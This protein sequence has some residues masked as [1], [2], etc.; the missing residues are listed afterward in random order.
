MLGQKSII[1]LI[2]LGFSYFLK[3]YLTWGTI[4][5]CFFTVGIFVTSL[6]IPK[7][8][9][10]LLALVLIGSYIF[11]YGKIFDPEVGLNF[12]TSVV[13]LKI[14]EN[15]TER[16]RYMIFFGLILLTGAGALFEK[17]LEYALFLLG[18]FFFLLSHF[19]KDREFRWA[20]KE[21]LTSL[22]LILPLVGTLFFVVPRIMSPMSLFGAQ[23]QKGKIGYSKSVNMED[24]DSLTAND[25][26]AFYAVVP[27]IVPQ[28]ELYWRGNVLTLTDGWNWIEAPKETGVSLRDEDFEFK[29]LK[30]EI[31]LLKPSDYFFMLDWPLAL[32]TELKDRRIGESGT[33]SQERR[34]KVQRYSVWSRKESILSPSESR[35][36]TIS[37]LKARDKKW[38]KETFQSQDAQELIREIQDY[39]RNENFTYTLSPGR[40]SSFEEFMK[41][42]RGFCT[43]FASA[44]AQILRAKGIPVRLISGYMGGIYNRIGGYYQVTENDAH[45]W[46]EVPSPEGWRRFDPTAW[47]SPERV[48]LGGDIFVK[49][50]SGAGGFEL[51]EF[52]PLKKIGFIQDLR[53]EFERLNFDFYRLLEEMNYFTQLTLLR[54]MGLKKKFMLILIPVIILFFAA[55]YLLILRILRREKDIEALAWRKFRKKL[56]ARESTSLNSIREIEARIKE[57]EAEKRFEAQRVLKSLVG[58]SFGEEKIAL[59]SLIKEI[60]RL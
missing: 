49:E 12:L 15:E 20:K 53:F 59:D 10:V 21:I 22:L 25:E 27:Q 37:A 38:V 47:I 14:L 32:R 60:R 28:N 34:E 51:G 56:G 29:G 30:Q 55:L 36:L 7:F 11:V 57:M 6:K 54:K 44:T 41:E 2:I 43:H 46:V 33:L 50:K 17:T 35:G 5:F 45:V 18:S 19:H 8:L 23:K 4:V 1:A 31:F 40:I 52:N 39:F 13:M 42:K 26:T 48:S 16:D 3:D 58:H 24:V 9:R